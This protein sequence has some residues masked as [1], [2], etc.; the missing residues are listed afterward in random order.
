LKPLFKHLEAES[1]SAYNNS[2]PLTGVSFLELGAGAGI[3]SWTAMARGARV[4]CTDQPDANR[5]R[6]LAECIERNWRQMNASNYFDT[7]HDSHDDSVR[8]RYGKQTKCCPYLWGKVIDEVIAALNEK[9][10]ERFDVIVAADCVY[11][12]WLHNELL[13]SIDMLLSNRGVALLPFALHGNTDDDDVWRI[14]ERARDKGFVVETLSKAQ[15]TPQ[16][17]GM[18]LKQG[19]V[20]TVRLTK[21]STSNEIYKMRTE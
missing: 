9:E 18:D 2:H 7:T 1:E 6:C 10:G 8:K 14:V 19:L 16:G 11:M 21:I 12:P 4:V 17:K 3:P 20:H 5:F 15:L 13:D